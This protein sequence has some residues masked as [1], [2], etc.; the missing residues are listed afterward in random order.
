MEV[1]G[2]RPLRDNPLSRCGCSSLLR[3][4]TSPHWPISIGTRSLSGRVIGDGEVKRD[5][6]E[7]ITTAPRSEAAHA[8]SHI[9]AVQ[10]A[11]S[12]MRCLF[13]PL[14]LQGRYLYGKDSGSGGARNDCLLWQDNGVGCGRLLLGAKNHRAEAC[15]F[16]VSA[17]G[18]APNKPKHL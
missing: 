6:S 4:L 13:P 14:S 15:P 8:A 2:E 7:S 11:S 1:W 18:T 10:V 17:H 3:L 5:T 9:L 12:V 16:G